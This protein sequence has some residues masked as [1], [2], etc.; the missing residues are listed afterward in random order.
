M[1]TIGDFECPLRKISLLTTLASACQFISGQDF[2][3]FLIWRKDGI[4]SYELA[5]VVDDSA[6]EIS[7][8]V[9]GEDLLISTARQLLLY[10][11]LGAT[12][13]KFYHAPSLLMKLNPPF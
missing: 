10:E 13:P 1:D 2:G 5:V 6:M 4:P 7:E 12:V 9:R 3:D 8:V 11:A